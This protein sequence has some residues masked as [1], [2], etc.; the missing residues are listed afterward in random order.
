MHIT[1]QCSRHLRSTLSA[2]HR[3]L[4]R[5]FYAS[6]HVYSCYRSLGCFK[7]FMSECLTNIILLTKAM[8]RGKEKGGVPSSAN[9]WERVHV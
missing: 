9:N 4:F 3:V 1:T 6:A 7:V 8:L 2:L 5:F